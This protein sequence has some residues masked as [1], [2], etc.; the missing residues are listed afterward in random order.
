MWNGDTC[1]W[2]LSLFSKLGGTEITHFTFYRT[3]SFSRF[4]E[5]IGTSHHPRIAPCL[6]IWNAHTHNIM[7]RD[8]SP[9]GCYLVLSFLKCGFWP[10]F[11]ELSAEKEIR[12]VTRLDSLSNRSPFSFFHRQLISTF[13]YPNKWICFLSRPHELKFTIPSRRN[14][15]C[16][17]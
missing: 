4:V 11:R 14:K 10:R 8:L 15:D 13:N 2:N 16:S 1:L 5:R 6:I 9:T 3:F 7:T 12:F 17:N